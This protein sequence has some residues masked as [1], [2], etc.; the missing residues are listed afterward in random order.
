MKEISGAMRASA[1]SGY[2]R[3]MPNKKAALEPPLLID[4]LRVIP[5]RTPGPIRR[6]LSVWLR[7]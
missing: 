3:C 6:G 2:Q 7:R 5:T 4:Y 1:I